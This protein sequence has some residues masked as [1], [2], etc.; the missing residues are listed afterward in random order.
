MQEANIVLLACKPYLAEEVLGEPG[1]REALAGKLVIS[2]MAGK[3]P[4]HIEKYI[5]RDS[6]SGEAES[7]D[8]RESNAQRCSSSASVDDHHRDQQQSFV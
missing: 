3:T 4:E 5:Y 8:Y 2:I 6:P 1:V 7:G